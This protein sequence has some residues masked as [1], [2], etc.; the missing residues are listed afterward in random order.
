MRN[1]SLAYEFASAVQENNLTTTRAQIS[2]DIEAATYQGTRLDSIRVQSQ[3][4]NGAGK[5]SVAI[6]A[7]E[8]YKFV[9]NGRIYLADNNYYFSCAPLSF[10][11][12]KWQ[13]ESIDTL[14]FAVH[15]SLITFSP[16]TLQRDSQRVEFEGDL[17][18]GKEMNFDVQIKNFVVEEI[19]FIT[20]FD[21][22]VRR[23]K[24]FAEISTQQ[25]NSAALHE[26]IIRAAATS[27]IFHSAIIFSKYYSM[28]VMRKNL[29]AHGEF[30]PPIPRPMHFCGRK[31]AAG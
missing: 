11:R 12:G 21:D 15:P 16:N 14:R 29:T 18:N 13:W 27:E 9:T 26:P 17:R 2:T 28:A 31:F 20:S 4:E 6:I 23:M 22:S 10:I 5:F 24:I 3:F 7:N 25:Q 19:P 8:Q 30:S 1:A